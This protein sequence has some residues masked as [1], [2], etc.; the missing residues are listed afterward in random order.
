MSIKVNIDSI[1]DDKRIKIDKELTIKIENKSNFIPDKTII[2]YDIIDENIYLPFAYANENDFLRP[3][4]KNFPSM[5]VKFEGKLRDE[6]KI[7]K[8]DAI[9]YLNKTGSIIIS[10]Y[11]GAGKTITSINLATT[12]KLKT[13]VIVNKIVL[14]NQWEES[15]LSFCPSALVQKLTTKSR[16]KDDCDFY[17]M[18]AINIEKM[19]R[20]FFKNIGLVICD[21]VHLILADTLSRSLQYLCP[22]YLIGLSATPYRPDGLNILLDFYFG[23][24]K[25]IKEMYREHIVYKVKTE[26]TPNMELTENGKVNWNSVLKSQSEDE[27]RNNLIINIVKHFSDRNFLVLTKRVTQAKYIYNQLLKSGQNVTSLIGTQQEFD[28]DARILV[29]ITNKCGTGFDFPKLNALI[30]CSDLKEFFIQSLGRIFRTK[31]TIPIV[32]DLLDNN[33][34]LFRHYMERRNV[35]LKHGGKIVDFNKKFPEFFKYK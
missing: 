13:L 8:K 26:L 28:R 9:E 34:I 5:N 4:R 25:I 23:K 6:Q 33:P 35:Y 3:N 21:E 16:L 31:D 12:I 15:I 7:V 17:I 2:P 11:T 22:R 18:N 30:L 24:N 19:G 1:S 27:D 32:F 10:L 29:G 14:M 20:K